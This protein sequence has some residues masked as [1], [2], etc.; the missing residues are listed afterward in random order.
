MDVAGVIAY[1]TDQGGPGEPRLRDLA[2][3]AE[4]GRGLLTVDALAATWSWTG[5]RK[6]APSAL[7]SRP[8]PGEM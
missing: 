8:G 4:G 3:L 7:P 1:V 6:A 5:T 2:E